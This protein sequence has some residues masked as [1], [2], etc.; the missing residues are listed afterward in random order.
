MSE[1]KAV[2]TDKA[3]RAIGPYS[4][5]L[6]A[7]NTLYISGQL[8]I[9]PKSDQLVEGGTAAQTKQAL[10]NIM[11]VL[12]E[13]NMSMSNIVQMQIFLTD[14]GDFKMVNEVYQT[15]FTE[16]Y[17]ARAAVQVAALPKQ[18]NVEILSIAIKD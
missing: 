17:P 8:G 14:I 18:A 4:Q 7:G 11:A 5:G 1:R 9:D 3:P 6:L 12:M 13:V 10:E 2:Q 16:P 15:F